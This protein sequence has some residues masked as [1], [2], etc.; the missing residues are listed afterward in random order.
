MDRLPIIKFMY[1][2]RILSNLYFLLLFLIIV[3]SNILF[4]N[5]IKLAY[6]FYDMKLDNGFV[7]YI[8]FEQVIFYYFYIF[9][10]VYC[11]NILC[12]SRYG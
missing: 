10:L 6:Y 8:F 9:L 7:Q 11:F 5:D 1:C 4:C 2:L 12:Y 3:L